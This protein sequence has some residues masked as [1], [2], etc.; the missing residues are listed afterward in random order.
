[1]NIETF[2]MP[3]SI[4]GRF[5]LQQCTI[6]KCI[7]NATAWKVPA[8]T[9]TDIAPNRTA[10]E[11]WYKVVAN[12]KT[13]SVAATASRNE[14]WDKLSV[15]L[16]DLYDTCLLNNAAIS[17][18]DKYALG[19]KIT[20]SMIR[21]VGRKPVTTPV[22]TLA[23][24]EVSI[25]HVI[26]ADSATPNTHAKPHGIA[27]LEL[28]AKIGVATAPPASAADCTVNFNISRNHEAIEF[29]A[30]D[31]GKT[32]FTYSRWVTTT[33]EVSPWGGVVVAIIP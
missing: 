1:M 19:I 21:V 12:I 29:D 18:D 10:Y 22:V 13:R 5:D 9:L 7:T 6:E 26:Y 23:S 17:I 2:G 28:T 16:R 8:A 33:G 25:L 3:S 30:T 4:A 27:F 32:V 31:R 15:Q 11:L 20:D 24:G 14:A